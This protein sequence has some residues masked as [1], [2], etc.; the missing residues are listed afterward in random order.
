MNFSA[1]ELEIKN[2]ILT[3]LKKRGPG[4]SICPSEVARKLYPDNWREK[5]ENVRS[6]ARIMAKGGELRIT[7]R[8]KELDP[9]KIKG[10]I[11][12]RFIETK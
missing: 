9:D 2:C 4:K 1:E 3:L 8:D 7:Q 5:M 6:T 11:R 12:L 10:P